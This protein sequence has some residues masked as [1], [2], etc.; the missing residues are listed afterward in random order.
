MKKRIVILGISGYIGQYMQSFLSQ[1]KLDQKYDITGID[2]IVPRKTMCNMTFLRKDLQ[3]TS[4]LKDMLLN[5]SFDYLINLI[6]ITKSDNLQSFINLNVRFPG[7]LLNIISE[8]KIPHKKIL[9]IGSAAEYG[10][11]SDLPLKENSKL[12]P[13]G[14]YGLSKQLQTNIFDF[15]KKDKDL[16]L[17]LARVFNI[18]SENMPSS[19]A[20]GNFANQINNIKS[21]GNINTGDLSS[22]RDFLNIEDIVSAI[23]IILFEGKKSEIYN[24]CSGQSWQIKDLL[25]ILIKKSNKSISIIEKKSPINNIDDSY[26]SNVKL[27]SLG[28]VTTST[29][30]ETIEKMINK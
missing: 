6:G 2:V 29:V 1:S 24:I 7:N 30:P 12:I 5:S 28:W 23:L 20:L 3:D 26:G 9:L 4:C 15:Y 14:H 16:N 18:V 27:K 10:A 22:K 17:N 25:N 19:L 13:I 8:Y 11:N 21:S